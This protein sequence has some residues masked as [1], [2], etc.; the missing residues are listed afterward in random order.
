MT[1]IQID[2]F[3][4]QHPSG[5]VPVKISFKKRNAVVGVFVRGRDFEDLKAKNFWRI[6][7]EA[8]LASWKRSK[9]Q[10]LS[11]LFSGTEFVK[12]TAAT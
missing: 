11:R 7:P 2:K 1:I 3:I 12:L 4:E 5:D 8:D 9:D 10:R 6:I